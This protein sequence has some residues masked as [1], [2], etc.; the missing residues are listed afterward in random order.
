MNC[1]HCD[2]PLEPA[3]RDYSITRYHAP[4]C[5]EHQAWFDQMIHDSS[6]Y[7]TKPHLLLYLRLRQLGANPLLNYFDGHKTVDIAIAAAHL[8]LEVDGIHH[9]DPY[10]A[11]SDLK[12]TIYDLETDIVTIRIP[13]AL[14]KYDLFGCADQLLK[15]INRRQGIPVTKRDGLKRAIALWTR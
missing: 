3:V 8:H 2:L 6:K 10:Q 14:V 4:L 11:I 12:R 7:T 1:S 15:I 5:R 13:N 9:H